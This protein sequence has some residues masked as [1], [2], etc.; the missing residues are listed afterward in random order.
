MEKQTIAYPVER[1]INAGVS[2]YLIYF[3]DDIL[4]CLEEDNRCYRAGTYSDKPS[5][6]EIVEL[7]SRYSPESRTFK[8]SI[9]Q[10]NH[11][12]VRNGE[13]TD[14]KGLTATI[15]MLT[16]GCNLLITED[17]PIIDERYTVLRCREQ[18]TIG[19]DGPDYTFHPVED[20]CQYNVPNGGTPSQR[21]L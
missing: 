18:C 15:Y 21:Y 7:Q 17:L 8:G 6:H 11:Y 5:Y 14:S 9:T 19:E 13:T 10:E 3:G 2:A 1:L 20:D 4:L 12:A 16:N